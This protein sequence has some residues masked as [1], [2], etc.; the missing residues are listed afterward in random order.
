MST[1]GRAGFAA[2]LSLVALCAAPVQAQSGAA[3]QPLRRIEVAVGA[4]VLGG[5]SAGDANADLRA[6]SQTPRPYTLFE[7]ES[8]LSATRAGEFRAA[9]ALTRR[10]AVEARVA[11]AR[12]QLRTSIAGDAE[13]APPLI[14]AE[15]IDQ[16]Q[17]DG[18]LLVRLPELQMGR[19]LP[20]A[21]AGAGYLRELHEGRT[22]VEEGRVFHVG[23]GVRYPL[24]AR[25]AGVVKGAGLRADARLYLLSGATGLDDGPRAHG[26]LSGSLFVTF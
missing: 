21:S 8:R 12:P 11:F 17:F 9:V 13:G 4:G 15:T 16:Y 26:A 22:L 7:T 14:A 3:A 6:N 5:A 2:G 23:G 18:A 24:F 20:F 1:A 10:Y 19:V 25:Q